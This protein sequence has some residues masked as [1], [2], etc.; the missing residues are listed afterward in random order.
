MTKPT[1]PTLPRLRE[2]Y[3]ERTQLEAEMTRLKLESQNDPLK[4]A[5]GEHPTEEW[6]VHAREY[7]SERT[8]IVAELQEVLLEIVEVRDALKDEPFSMASLLY[9]IDALVSI[10]AKMKED[11]KDAW[12]N[13]SSFIDGLEKDEERI[14][15]LKEKDHA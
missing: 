15:N 1:N 12:D 5:V 10:E 7:A 13:L 11:P 4:P 2:L 6:L 3:A 9:V 8:E 14:Y